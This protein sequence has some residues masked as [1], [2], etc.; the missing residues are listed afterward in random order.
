MAYHHKIT[1]TQK[2]EKGDEK[3]RNEVLVKAIDKAIL[4]IC[5]LHN[6]EDMDWHFEHEQQNSIL[7][8]IAFFVDSQRR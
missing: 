4:E 1:E 8:R 2:P 6:K 5:K 3:M 7:Q